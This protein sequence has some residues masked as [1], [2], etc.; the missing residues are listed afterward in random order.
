MGPAKEKMKVTIALSYG[1]TGIVVI[2]KNGYVHLDLDL[3]W[4][5]L[6][7]LPLP[8]LPRDRLDDLL[9]LLLRFIMLGRYFG[10]LRFLS[11]LAISWGGNVGF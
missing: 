9:L 10:N 3:L 1:F 6:L 4:V 5:P 11:V 7:L 8:L 2:P